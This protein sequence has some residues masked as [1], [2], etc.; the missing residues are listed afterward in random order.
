[1][2]TQ[3]EER[4]RERARCNIIYIS[5]LLLLLYGEMESERLVDSATTDSLSDGTCEREKERERDL[6][7]HAPASHVKYVWY[8]IALH[9]G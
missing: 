9:W 5:L 3:Y 6:T 2:Y 7:L 4:E 8:Y 1:M